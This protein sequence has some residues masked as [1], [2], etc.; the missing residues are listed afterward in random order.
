MAIIFELPKIGEKTTRPTSCPH[1]GGS[2]LQRWG[3]HKK[4]L[5]DP[6]V[7]EVEVT[8]YRCKQCERTFRVYPE[9]VNR[10]QR[11]LRMKKLLVLMWA[12]GLSYRGIESILQVFGISLSHMSSWREVQEAGKELRRKLSQKRV[13]VAGIDGAWIQ[14]KGVMVAVDMGDGQIL[15]LARIDEK[16]TAALLTWV[17]ELQEKHHIQAIVTDDLNTYKGIAR[18]LGLTHQVCQFHV[19]R[20]TGGALSRL[21]KKVSHQ[22]QWVIPQIRMILQT[23]PPDGDE[24]LFQLWLSL[25]ARST[26]PTEKRTP[27]EKLRD[28]VLRLSRDWQRYLAFTKESDIPWTNNRTEQCIGRIKHRA[29][30]VRGYKSEPGMLLGSLIAAQRGL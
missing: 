15:S 7:R 5:K 16:D 29:K 28:L 6:Q 13:R 20:W 24:Q 11:S 19:R 14:G 23:L 9:G 10:Q 21:E 1:C 30:R 27:L 2:I 22:W 25:P 12:L 18:T 26:T 3:K 17:K 8:R 4:T